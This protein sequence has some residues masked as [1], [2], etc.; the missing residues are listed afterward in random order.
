MFLL[1]SMPVRGQNVILS[2]KG[3]HK[4]KK[5]RLRCVE[6]RQHLIN[7]FKLESRLYKEIC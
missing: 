2:R 3:R 1:Y 4:H 7:Y 5:R 6:V